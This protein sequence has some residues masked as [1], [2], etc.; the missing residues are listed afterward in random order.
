MFCADTF[1]DEPSWSVPT[2]RP[3]PRYYYTE[4]GVAAAREVFERVYSPK[5]PG[6]DDWTRKLCATR[7]CQPVISYLPNVRALR[8]LRRP[9]RQLYETVCWLDLRR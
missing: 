7:S 6:P 5:N 4:E 8:L 1:G 2:F 3:G 9:V